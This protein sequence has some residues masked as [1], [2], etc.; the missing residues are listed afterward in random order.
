MGELDEYEEDNIAKGLIWLAK[1]KGDPK[2]YLFWLKLHKKLFENVWSWAGTIRPHELNNP[3]FCNPRDIWPR[4]YQL[5]QDLNA[6]LDF[7]SYAKDYIVARFHCRILTIHPF[8]NG[9]GR[10]SRILA[11]QICSHLQIQKPTW[12]VQ[13]IHNPAERRKKYIEALVTGRR[14]LDYTFLI[15]F[16]FS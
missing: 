3:D 7:N 16:M 11:E 2:K 5:E 10:F 12:G 15:H 4:L 9:N 13:F 8:A 14:K 1:Q 6:W